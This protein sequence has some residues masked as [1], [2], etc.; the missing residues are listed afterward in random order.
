MATSFLQP[1]MSSAPALRDAVA[2]RLGRAALR[3]TSSSTRIARALILAVPP[4][5]SD[6]EL[7]AKGS[8][9]ARR[10]LTL[11]RAMLDRL[12]RNDDPAVIRLERTP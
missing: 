11:R 2:D 1:R 4:S 6:G 3:A 12:Y 9:N 5:V 10:V 7:T 8:M